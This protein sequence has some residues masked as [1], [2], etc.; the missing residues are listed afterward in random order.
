M[1]F[2]D[3]LLSFLKNG[4]EKIIDALFAFIS[5]LAKPLSYVLAFLEG[6]FYFIMKI[7]DVVI[8]VVMIFVALFQFV[9]ALVVGLF[10]TIANWLTVSPNSA[11][12]AFPSASYQGLEVVIDLVQPTGLLTVVP[13]VCLAL[14]WM[15]FIIK[16]I[17]LFGGNISISPFGGGGAK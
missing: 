11:D 9:G 13:M 14:L 8:S 5:F 17:G 10:R 7:F 1:K 12:V 6:V 3:K 4:F 15:Y 16:I 2:V